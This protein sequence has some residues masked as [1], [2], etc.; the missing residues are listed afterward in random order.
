MTDNKNEPNSIDALTGK[1]MPKPIPAATLVI[2]R[3][4]PGTTAPDLLMVE[5]SAKMAF[6]AGAAVFPGGRVDDADFDFA[7]S[8]GHEDVDE[9]G[10]RIAAIRESIE[11]TGIAVAVD[12]DV[13]ARRVTEARA[14]LHDGTIL[15]EICAQFDWQ[16]NL[17]KLVP[18]T[19][20]C[21]PFAE[22]RVF[23]TRFYM[24]AHEDH[25]AEA[26]VDE[27][28]NYNLF[29]SSAQGVLEKANA[30]DVKIIFPTKRNLERLAQFTSFD[31]AADHSAR[32]P[33][34]M[35]SPTVE[36]REDGVHLCIPEGIGYP[37]TSEPMEAVQRG[38]SK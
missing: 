29:W 28:E 17:D 21:P 27:T 20:W 10:A 2:F 35:V 11:E 19:R 34:T 14:A 4:Q 25:S 15:S 38:F 16:L 32:H 6:A 8:L 5:R 12:G 9:F 30:G 23:D 7:R 37:I 22:K 13:A 1:P 18:F 31:E 26:T 24:I 3:D 36:K 33:V